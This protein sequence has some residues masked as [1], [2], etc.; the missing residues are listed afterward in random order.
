MET[1]PKPAIE[2][3]CALYQLLSNLA[4]EGV[5]T[6]SSSELGEHLGMA[7][8][9]L[10]KDISYIGE[11]GN[12][13]AG[14]ETGKLRDHIGKAL[15]FGRERKACVVGLGR[16]GSALVQNKRFTQGDFRIV[17]GFDSNINR[18]ETLTAL[19][20]LYPAYQIPET[21][22]Q[23]GIELAAIA[24]PSLS[25]QDVADKLVEGGIKGLV[26]FS[27]VVIK[28][29]KAGVFV[30]NIDITGEFRKLS[31]LIGLCENEN[32]TTTK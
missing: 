28:P 3:L 18:V 11:V 30:R 6:V 5:A 25:V 22:R 14:Y 27:G 1:I 21:V 23:L 10:R 29:A 2:R 24:V 26:N 8:H 15:G 13:G 19:V 17:A 7:A 12:T 16:V 20:P 4:D 31:A 9:N 32:H